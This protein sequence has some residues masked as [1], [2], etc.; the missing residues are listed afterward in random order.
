MDHN[1]HS[2]NLMTTG[3]GSLWVTMKN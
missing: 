2:T 3:T 1:I